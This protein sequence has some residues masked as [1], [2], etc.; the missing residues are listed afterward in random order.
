M[1]NQELRTVT[2]SRSDMF[3]VRLALTHVMIDY[4]KEIANAETS[5]DRRQIA[6]SS[7]AMWERIRSAFTSQLYAQD[8]E[9]YRRN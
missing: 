1:L 4:R 6:E 8:P 9:E 7:L 3:K 5:E 2:M